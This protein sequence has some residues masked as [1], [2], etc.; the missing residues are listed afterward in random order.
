MRM[1]QNAV[2]LFIRLGF[3]HKK[4][5]PPDSTQLH[6]SW[7]KAPSPPLVTPTATPLTLETPGSD[8]EQALTRRSPSPGIAEPVTATLALL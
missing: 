8:S 3:A 2:S 7:A 4:T 1:S 6:S 5:T